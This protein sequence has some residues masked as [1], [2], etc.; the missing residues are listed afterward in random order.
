MTW[1]NQH[2]RITLNAVFGKIGAFSKYRVKTHLKGQIFKMTPRFKIYSCSKQKFRKRKKKLKTAA[3][4]R[5]R[6][7]Q[8]QCNARIPSH[9]S[10]DYQF[11]FA[12]YIKLVFSCIWSTWAN[13]LFIRFFGQI[14]DRMIFWFAAYLF[15]Y[16]KS[17][18]E[19]KIVYEKEN[20][21][22]VAC[23]QNARV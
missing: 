5:T 1:I 9:H 16:I 21:I 15:K 7:P 17:F 14:N 13:Y 10:H 22:W 4:K 19:W 8:V 20:V 6:D 23:L 12:K 11:K 2:P 18:V 3:G